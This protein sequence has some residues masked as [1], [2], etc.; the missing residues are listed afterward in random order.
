MQVTRGRVP[1][2]RTAVRQPE[3]SVAWGGTRRVPP[4]N[5]T[6]STPQQAGIRGLSGS[7]VRLRVNEK[8]PIGT[9]S[10]AHTCTGLH[11]GGE[12]QNRT[13]QRPKGKGAARGGLKGPGEGENPGTGWS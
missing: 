3:A 13:M 8:E 12:G 2:S 7:A 11:M 6:P 1:G 4:G 10:C 9:A 5:E